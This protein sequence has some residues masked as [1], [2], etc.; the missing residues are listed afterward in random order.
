M[1]AD[2]RRNE[3]VITKI[4][5]LMDRMTRRSTARAN[6]NRFGNDGDTHA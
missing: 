6:P 4:L 2:A 5:H 1:A 3:R